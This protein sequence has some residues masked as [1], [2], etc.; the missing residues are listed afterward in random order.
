MLIN[1]RV[2]FHKKLFLVNTSHKPDSSVAKFKEIF[3]LYLIYQYFELF[4]S[5]L[6]RV[7]NTKPVKYQNTSIYKA[8]NGNVSPCCQISHHNEDR[9]RFSST[10]KLQDPILDLQGLLIFFPT[11]WMAVTM[12]TP[13]RRGVGWADMNRAAKM[14]L[15]RGRHGSGVHLTHL[16]RCCQ[17]NVSGFQA[18]RRP[19]ADVLPLRRLLHLRL[20]RHAPEPEA[21]PVLGAPIPSRGGKSDLHLWSGLGSA[22]L[23]WT[24]LWKTQARGGP[25][26]QAPRNKEPAGEEERETIL[27]VYLLTPSHAP[28]PPSYPP[29]ELDESHQSQSSS[30]Y[31]P[32]AGEPAAKNVASEEHASSTKPP[33][34]FLLL[35]NPP[36][37]TKVTDP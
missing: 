24:H 2:V 5:L 31:W 6:V 29:T 16:L 22:S 3:R 23:R 18:Q 36:Q 32:A 25:I 11:F 1:P 33:Q 15:G 10:L 4:I 26:S 30:A 14:H 27:P 21:E 28:P 12:D 13:G 37:K 19:V 8:K 34:P 35:Q 7:I 9:S 17:R 20:L